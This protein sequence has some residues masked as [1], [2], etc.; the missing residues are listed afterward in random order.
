MTSV[1]PFL[2]NKSATRRIT[3]TSTALISTNAADSES[4]ILS[5]KPL[6][7]DKEEVDSTGTPLQ[8]SH[9]DISDLGECP[10]CGENLS[11]LGEAGEQEHHLQ[12]CLDVGSSSGIHGSKYL[13]K[14]ARLVPFPTGNAAGLTMIRA[15]LHITRII[16]PCKDRL[17][18]LLRGV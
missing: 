14:P 4:S 3:G 10:V 16:S 18:D 1:T 12:V 2:N 8:R 5:A 17:L 11:S 13:G 7:T 15:S 9:S 6:S